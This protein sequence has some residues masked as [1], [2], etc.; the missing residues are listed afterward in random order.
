LICRECGPPTPPPSPAVVLGAVRLRFSHRPP[1]RVFFL[2][3]AEAG[4]KRRS[5][6]LDTAHIR[7]RHFATF[8][9]RLIQQLHSGVLGLEEEE[10]DQCECS[11]TNNVFFAFTLSLFTPSSG[12]P[13]PRSRTPSAS[14]SPSPAPPG[15]RSH[16]RSRNRG[17]EYV[18]KSGMKRASDGTVE[19][20]RATEPWPHH[21]QRRVAQGL[22]DRAVDEPARA[23]P[24]PRGNVSDPGPGNIH[25]RDL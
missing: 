21:R 5:L 20:D 17:T 23:S 19:S 6:G 10:S 22:L 12:D 11:T 24:T 3:A 15:V 14:A 9:T 25:H 18:R 7:N 8:L 16:C 2:E 13:F 1:H 4:R